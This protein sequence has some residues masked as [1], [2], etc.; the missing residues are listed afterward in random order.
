MRTI[1]IEP[2]RGPIDESIRVPGS[3]S[4]TNRAL[5]LSALAA[6]R[7]TLLNLSTAGDCRD[8][9]GALRAIGLP[10]VPGDA[11]TLS[12][13]GYGGGVPDVGRDLDAG[14]GGTTTR[15]LIALAAA[16]SH[17]DCTIDAAPRMRERPVADLLDALGQLGA[18]IESTN[19]HLP[20]RVKGSGLIG[21]RAVIAGDVSS[22]FLSALLL[23]APTARQP[24]ELTVTGTLASRPYVEM[25]I[26]AMEAF[27]I[28]VEREGDAHFR[29]EPAVYRSPGTFTIE[30]D[31]S[32]ASYFF[33]IPSLV[34]G[35]VRVDA[36][37]RRSWQGDVGF[38]DVLGEMGCEVLE[39]EEGMIL[40][41]DGRPGGIDW[42]L[43]D[44]PDT[45]QT[46]AAIA[47]FAS[48]PVTIRGIAS[49][50]LKEC[51]RVSAT[52]RELA[53]LGVEVVER[54]DGMVIQPCHHMHGDRVQTYDDHRMA[55]AFALAG[56]RV[57]GIV[58]ENPGCVAKS[59]PEFFDVLAQVGHNIGGV[60]SET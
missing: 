53:R 3:K 44:M 39:E 22:Q 2:V 17:G 23:V 46:L 30:S 24:V 54:E 16:A 19:G 48:S 60:R 41:S 26:A 15:F 55:M 34:G 58:I 52:C 33:A 12:I 1:T 42:D 35:R 28:A 49:A 4:L 32:S 57:P 47:P 38:L 7:T 13:D 25:T 59:F 40:V 21:G 31:A 36:I 8:M 51:D 6:G 45:A 29:I 5:V 20:V 43:G 50:R 56:L 18:Q 37:T 9:V 14:S 10:A 27:G 11:G